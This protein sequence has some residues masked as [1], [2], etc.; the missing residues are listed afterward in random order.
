MSTMSSHFDCIVVGAGGAMGAATCFELA[1]RGV[2]VLGLDQFGIAHDRGSSHGHSRMIR[3]CYYE[4][5]DYV[6]LLRRAYELWHD[7][8]QASGERLLFTPGGAY[9]G[10]EDAEAVGGS[11]RAAL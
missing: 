6:P 7:L 8:E 11:R 10:R 3:M 2:R 1:R 9:M 4:H 5:P